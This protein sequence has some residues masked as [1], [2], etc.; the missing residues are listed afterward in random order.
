[1]IASVKCII[2]NRSCFA[3]S[4]LFLFFCG[5]VNAQTIKRPSIKV[6]YFVET[7]SS[8][9]AIAVDENGNPLTPTKIIN[10]TLYIEGLNAKKNAIKLI[11][12]NKKKV[13]FS[14]DS[15]Y[16]TPHCVGV[17][18][19]TN[20]SLCIKANSNATKVQQVNILQFTPKGNSKF[21]N[22]LLGIRFNKK[23]NYYHFKLPIT[24]VSP[25]VLLQ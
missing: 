8:P 16:L 21:Q 23:I 1:M 15:C 20:D 10:Y 4:I 7:I 5:D 22:I 25:L 17:H 9:G 2:F 19:I 12:I 24:S 14:V 3:A 11:Q 6:N 18:T 13:Q